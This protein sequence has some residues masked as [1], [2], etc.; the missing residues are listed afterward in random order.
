MCPY[1]YR[2]KRLLSSKVEF[3]EIDLA[4]SARRDEMVARAEAA[5]RAA[6][7]R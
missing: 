3:T 7:L 4:V 2:A 5:Y 1:C 6:D